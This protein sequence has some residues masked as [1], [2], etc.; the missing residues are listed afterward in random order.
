MSTTV[1]TVAS[2]PF[3]NL[4]TSSIDPVTTATKIEGGLLSA[5]GTPQTV[6]PGR[7]SGVVAFSGNTQAL[8]RWDFLDPYSTYIIKSGSVVVGTAQAGA[9]SALITGL[10][11]GT[12]YT[13]TVTASNSIGSGLDSLASNSVTPSVGPV[14][15]LPPLALWLDAN[16]LGLSNGANVTSWTDKSGNGRNGVSSGTGYQTFTAPTFLASWANSTPAVAFSGN[17]Q[18]LTLAGLTAATVGQNASIVIIGDCT[19]LTN[20]GS[21]TNQQLLTNQRYVAQPLWDDQ[22]GL[23]V[24]T[25]SGNFNA[26][27]A[28]G[29]TSSSTITLSAKTILSIDLPGYLY[30][31]GTKGSKRISSLASTQ[32]AFVL[33]SNTN[34]VTLAYTGRVAEVIVTPQQLTQSQRW[35]V[36]AYAAAKYGITVVQQ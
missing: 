23:S 2:S 22:S 9:S 4:V 29:L 34:G 27:S 32:T 11:N 16:Q 5:I 33:G 6:P 21:Q 14:A 19:S 31:N 26:I 10:T 24:N 20:S 30:V 18:A 28:G 25:A 3:E 7:V 1:N 35:A 36:E 17:G 15:G 12:A 13:F 8:V